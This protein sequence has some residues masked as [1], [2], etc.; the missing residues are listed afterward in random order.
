MAGEG[1][2]ALGHQ[3]VGG[4]Q[5]LQQGVA[6]ARHPR[7]RYVHLEHCTLNLVTGDR[8]G[9]ETR[10]LGA[11]IPSPHQTD[12]QTGGARAPQGD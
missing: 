4:L 9:G 1:E 8:W 6:L 11:V 12:Y 10:G 2:G 5:L 3:G 7:T